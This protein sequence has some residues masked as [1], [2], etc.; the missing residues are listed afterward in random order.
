LGRGIVSLLVAIALLAPVL[1]LSVQPAGPVGHATV[2]SLTGSPETI[3]SE[4]LTAGEVAIAGLHGG[5]LENLGQ[6]DDPD[7]RLYALGDGMSAG[8]TSRG[9]IY[10]FYRGPR[11][12][13]QDG[14]GAAMA[15]PSSCSMLLDLG[16]PAGVEP[17]GVGPLGHRSN[18]LL[19]SDP[20]LWHT[21]VRSFGEVLYE[22]LRDGIDLRF[23]CVDGALKYELV[24]APWADASSI[25]LS[26]Q[27]IGGLELDPLTGDLLIP[28]ALGTLRDP[29]P[30]VFQERQE[31]MWSAPA[32]FVLLGGGGF[33]FALP[34]G[35][36]PDAPYIIDPGIVFSTLLGGIYLDQVRDVLVAEDGGVYVSGVSYSTDFPVTGGANN[37]DPDSEWGNAFLAKLDPTG[38]RLILS[39]YV[40]G[41][42]F[43]AAASMELAP[44]GGIY[45]IGSTTG[46]FP[47]T[48]DAL[49]KTFSGVF[50]VFL[51][52]LSADGSDLLYSTYFGGSETDSSV[53]L[54]VGADGDVYI[55][56]PTASDDLPCTP[57]AYCATY[58][59]S[60]AGAEAALF[61]IR[62][63][64]SLTSLRYCT[65]V[66]GLG[67]TVACQRPKTGLSVDDRGNAY[68]CGAALKGLPTTDG[69]CHPAYLGGATDGFVL[70]L[71]PS[72]SRLL[73]STFVGGSKTDGATAVLVSSNGTVYVTGYTNSIDM[74]TTPDAPYGTLGGNY[75]FFV[76]ALDKTM[77]EVTFSSYYGGR[78]DDNAGEL[79]LSSDGTLLA[80]MGTTWSASYPCT[81]GCFDSHLDG[82]VDLALLTLNLTTRRFDYGT[83]LGGSDIDTHSY[84]GLAACP[85]GGFF[86]GGLT[87][88]VDFPTTLG[89]FETTYSGNEDGFLALLDPT[90]CDVPGPPR[91]L[92]AV[93]DD[94]TVNLSWAPHTNEGYLVL[95]YRVYKGE[96]PD[97]LS[98]V[99]IVPATRNWTVDN[100]VVNG[101]TY[102]YAVS[103]VNSAGE[104]VTNRTSARPLGLPTGPTALSATT[105]NGTVNLTW[106][107][108]AYAGGELLGY[109]MLRGTTNDSLSPIATDLAEALYEDREVAVGTSYW[110][111]VRAFNSRG[112]GPASEAIE[113]KAT[114]HPSP[115]RHFSALPGDLCTDLVWEPPESDGGSPVLGYRIYRASTDQVMSF[116]AE[117]GP[118]TLAYTDH[119]RG[120]GERY[121]Y[122]VTCRT[123]VGESLPTQMLEAVPFGFPGAPGTLVATAGDGTTTLSWSPPLDA[124]GRPVYGYVVYYGES[125]GHL[126]LSNRTGN[127]TT[128]V[129][130]GLTNG[131]T[132][133]YEVAAVNEAGEGL[134]RT[135]TVAATPMGLPGAVEDFVG[136]CLPGVIQLRWSGPADTGGSTSL[137]YTLLRG[138]SNDALGPIATLVDQWQY[139]DYDYLPGTTYFYR[140]IVSSEV[141]EGPASPIVSVRVFAPPREVT[142]LV[143]RPGNGCVE[144]TW[145]PPGDDGGSGVTGY[146]I[147]RGTEEYDLYELVQ[148]GPVGT[149]NDSGLVNGVT[150]Y[151]IVRAM[152]QVGTGP[153][154]TMANATPLGLP[155]PPT[156]FW[157][158]T[159]DGSVVLRWEPPTGKGTSPVR[160]YLVMR[161]TTPSGLVTIGELGTTLTYVDADVEAD[162]TYYY[163]IVATSAMGRGVASPVLEVAT[164]PMRGGTDGLTGLLPFVIVIVIVAVVVGVLVLALRRGRGRAGP[165]PGAETGSPP[166]GDAGGQQASDGSMDRAVTDRSRDRPEEPGR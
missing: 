153:V 127:A 100:A 134:L 63:D 51:C 41:P 92:V 150:L 136:N 43:D 60:T 146:V 131:V 138:T 117:R 12:V 162:S 68:I 104:G 37:T 83:Y 78:G 7:V 30:S 48:Q 38:S 3:D 166:R 33:T 107:P 97:A 4:A 85:E 120:N 148:V 80:V 156:L 91:D 17:V 56:G 111:A 94:G 114:S 11:G 24:V 98:P 65:Y 133:Y 44:D 10:T 99:A 14:V 135:E 35:L 27:G 58:G 46:G 26:Y 54:Q 1:A 9:V 126:L 152:N 76:A 90:G 144:L 39:T 108:P 143:A 81:A 119:V 25:A 155:G 70:M 139:M 147:L 79:A 141:G 123:D 47:V 42:L 165:D 164:P 31:G 137:T 82:M 67:P 130:T 154:S 87:D 124:N 2:P 75:D 5:F 95:E 163:C 61:A 106:S 122:Q 6:V 72:G 15:G 16:R 29:R 159:R 160:G 8:F 62:I 13:G 23:K 55:S 157:F 112:A 50:D 121:F 158:E 96:A 86:V 36:S 89:A 40:G 21:G 19:S 28:T 69:S 77:D 101:K 110:Y 45:I 125:P 66:N 140:V 129:H 145:S 142:A 103:A 74:D 20:A 59:G 118:G 18:F 22:G 57:G 128:F 84:E 52:K 73:S 53:A 88:S 32:A 115:P 64:A 102:H 161:G 109:T 105:G 116:I 132:Y 93:A 113:I 34:E 71:D 151:Y 149:Y 49:F